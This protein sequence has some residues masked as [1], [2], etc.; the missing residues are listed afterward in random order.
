MGAVHQ[1][2]GRS[3]VAGPFLNIYS[4]PALSLLAAQGATSWVM[5][6]EM[7]QQGLNAML[8][9]CPADLQTEVF[10]FGR[11]PL[12]FSARCFTARN[13]NLPKDNCQYVCLEYPDGRS[14]ERRVGKEWRRRM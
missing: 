4:P 8:K 3:F 10:A 5:P 12:A 6:L 1:M 13:R 14:E 7:D 9:E 11:M 2:Q